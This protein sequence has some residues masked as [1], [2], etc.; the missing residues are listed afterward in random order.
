MAKKP[1]VTLVENAADT[2]TQARAEDL[3]NLNAEEGG[4]LFRAI[5][6]ARSTQGAEVI[7]TRT[8]PADTAGFVD[9]IPVAEF[10][11]SAVKKRYGP[12][13]YRVR[14][15]GPTGFLPGGGT[16]KIAP[17][18]EGAS[19]SNGGGGDFMS[20]IEFFE[21]RDAERRRES[22]E[23]V[24]QVLLACIPV[25]GSVLTALLG[26]SQ[27]PDVL[28]LA[29]AMKPPPGPTLGD[30][31]QTMTGLHAMTAA[32][33]PPESGI[34]QILKV[35]EAVREMM[36]DSDSKGGSSWMD[37]VRDLIKAAPEAIQP[38]LAARMQ[39]MQNQP[40]AAIPQGSQGATAPPAA[41]VN[42][43][44][45][46]APVIASV[47]PTS[48]YIAADSS[49]GETTMFEL[50]RPMI[51]EKLKLIAGWAELDSD[52]VLCARILCDKHIPPNI[53]KFLPQEK[54]LQYLRFEQWFEKLLEWEPAFA[55]HREWCDEFRLELIEIV[56]MTDNEAAPAAT[57]AASTSSY[58]SGTEPPS[59]ET[60]A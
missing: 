18:P 32:K 34:D 56:S 23:K 26:R 24:N 3:A 17:L 1:S 39:A 4:A 41:R 21:K 15:N 58:P 38:I 19:K 42:A 16:I 29:A 33:S 45:P 43:P 51:K 35:M 48:A 7:L 12:G 8:M 6:E 57:P 59:T 22:S 53:D 31:V 11:L 36:P 28:A 14:F 50:A 9:K 55:E 54:A 10:D 40:G 49:D 2:E 5:E 30:I 37:I 13:T 60:G 47:A 44:A 25:A 52:P 20:A 27:G 46:S